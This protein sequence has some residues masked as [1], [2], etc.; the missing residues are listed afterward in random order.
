MV[1]TTAEWKKVAAL[2]KHIGEGP[3]DKDD[4]KNEGKIYRLW[5]AADDT[6]VAVK[7]A[8]DWEGA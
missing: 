8:A 4:Y 6:S 3:Y 7:Q 5:C 1:L 2:I